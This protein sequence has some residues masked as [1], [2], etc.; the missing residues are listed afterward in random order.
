M[1]NLISAPRI[2][3]LALLIIAWLAYRTQ[4]MLRT[5]L[6]AIAGAVLVLTPLQ[7]GKKHWQR[8]AESLRLGKESVVVMLYDILFWAVLA[9]LTLILANVLRGHYDQ[10]KAMDLGAGFTIAKLPAYNAILQNAFTTAIVAIIIF[11]IL[12]VVAYSLSRGLIWLTLLE[13]PVKAG[14]FKWFT[15]LNIIWCTAWLL[16]ALFFM[17]TMQSMFGAY[18]FLVLLVLYAH[19]TTVLHDAY[20]RTQEFGRAFRGAFGIGLGRLGAFLHPYCYLFIAYVIL[21]QLQR[22]AQGTTGLVITFVIFLVFM[23]F[24]RTYF[25]NILRQLE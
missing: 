6:L 24:Y 12:V 3:G 2:I 1:K 11:W 10:L 5:S 19:L 18:F 9:V 8:F 13:K 7:S 17:S 25:R 15:L 20:T 21:S 23:A 22:F 14:F 16:L 4:G